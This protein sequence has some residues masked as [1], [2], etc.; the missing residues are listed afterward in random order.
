MSDERAADP[1]GADD[2]ESGDSLKP[3]GGPQRVVSEESVDD[4][5][6][7]LDETKSKSAD[8][9]DTTV[10]TDESDAVT[11]TFD[12]D[13]VP[14]AAETTDDASQP[15]AGSVTE[16][17]TADRTAA[18]S[19]SDADATNDTDDTDAPSE[20]DTT[21]NDATT[22]DAA[23]SS[24]PDDASLEDLAARIE[25]GAVTGADVRAAEAGEG[26]ES[27]PEIDDVDLSLDDLE[28][29][30]AGAGGTDGDADVPDDAGP[31]A[32][33]VDRDGASDASDDGDES[34]DAPGLLGRIKNFFSR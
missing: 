13:D 11:A 7:S 15:D 21:A 6:A 29:S 18:D 31:L 23:A 9:S 8:S 2:A 19:E 14:A 30:E 17:A 24:L 20:P 16:T 27:T 22:V 26:R 12:E 32:G 10:T 5:L 3:S 25:E 34:N 28:T 4:I 33:S 1:D